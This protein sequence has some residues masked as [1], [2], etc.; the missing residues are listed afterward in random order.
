MWRM[1]QQQ[2]MNDYLICSGIPISLNSFIEK[3]FNQLDL[4]AQSYVQIDYFIKSIGPRD[5][6]WR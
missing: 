1:L 5:H 3:V 4:D 2:E 6:L